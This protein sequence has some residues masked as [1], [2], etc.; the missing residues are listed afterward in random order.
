[1]KTRRSGLTRRTL[2]IMLVAGHLLAAGAYAGDASR[3][4]PHRAAA[5]KTKSSVRKPQIGP[6]MG[7]EDSFAFKFAYR[8]AIKRLE[9]N[10]ACRALFDGLN[11]DGL[12]A[13]GR[14]RYQPAQSAAE[15]AHC[16]G[17]VAAYTAVGANRVMICSHF[18]RLHRRTKAAV[19]IHEAL[20]SAGMTEAPLDPDAM[21]ATEIET[22][23]EDACS[24]S[25]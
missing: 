8:G 9:K 10:E 12:Q 13:L 4:V 5:K 17:G 20:H 19:L 1:M 14:S 3:V 24:L 15:R 22:M 2:M 16:V 18:H 6:R 23:V 11:I 21:T 25:L 7:A